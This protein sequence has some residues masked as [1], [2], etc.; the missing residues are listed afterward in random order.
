[1]TLSNTRIVFVLALQAAAGCTT[2]E[3][4]SP[5]ESAGASASDE[6]G[7]DAFASCKAT[8]ACLEDECPDEVGPALALFFSEVPWPENVDEVFA[9]VEECGRRQCDYDA[10]DDEHWT[11]R[12]LMEQLACEIEAS[13]NDEDPDACQEC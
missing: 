9:A 11:T 5:F 8:A 4:D 3:T 12:Q 2:V 1:M 6:N 10:P 7:G 13:A